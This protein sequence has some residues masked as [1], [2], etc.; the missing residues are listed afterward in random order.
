MIPAHV[1]AHKNP[2]G[3]HNRVN[4]V[5]VNSRKEGR[6]LSGNLIRLNENTYGELLEAY[7]LIRDVGFV[8]ESFWKYHE[9]YKCFRKVCVDEWKKIF[10]APYL[11]VSMMA[12]FPWEMYTR[13]LKRRF[14]Q[15][16]KHFAS[17][18][19][20]QTIAYWMQEGW[21]ISEDDLYSSYPELEKM[22]VKIAKQPWIEEYNKTIKQ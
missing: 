5:L 15:L 11:S 2:S 7:D 1:M 21:V 17:E 22:S 3:M 14:K 9:L 18:Y 16:L 12:K 4:A 8:P 20:V 6:K 13:R 10:R 19:F